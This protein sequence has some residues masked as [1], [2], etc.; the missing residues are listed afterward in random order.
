MTHE[1]ISYLLDGE[2]VQHSPIPFIT[3]QVVWLPYPIQAGVHTPGQL[4]GAAFSYDLSNDFVVIGGLPEH[5]ITEVL[6]IRRREHFIGCLV[7]ENPLRDV[8]L[9]PGI[10]CRATNFDR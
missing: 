4:E 3:Q 6:D 2:T 9:Q 5:L 7:C 8:D 1:A 10:Q